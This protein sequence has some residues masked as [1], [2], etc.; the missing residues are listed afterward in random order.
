MKGKDEAFLLIGIAE[1]GKIL[2][3]DR[4]GMPS[5]VGADNNLSAIGCV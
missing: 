5:D 4:H 1:H 2:I 3:H